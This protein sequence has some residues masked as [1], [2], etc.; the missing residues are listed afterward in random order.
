MSEEDRTILASWMVRRRALL[1]QR[2]QEEVEAELETDIS[3]L[4]KSTP[5]IR[6]LVH[7]AATINLKDTPLETAVLTIWDPAEEQ[8]SI[9]NE[10][11]VI[12]V[13]GVGVHSSIY[14]GFLQLSS[15]GKSPMRR[16]EPAA[17]S[18]IRK[19][20]GFE[21]RKTLN[22]F[23]AHV[24]AHRNDNPTEQSS[25]VKRRRTF[26]TVGVTV[27]PLMPSVGGMPG[28]ELYLTDQ[29]WLL[30]RVHFEKSPYEL[31]KLQARDRVIALNDL[32]MLEFDVMTNCA[33]ARYTCLSSVSKVPPE[34]LARLEQWRKESPSELERVSAYLEARVP[35]FESSRAATIIG[36]I[37]GLNPSSDASMLSI[38]VDSGGESSH[39]LSL[40]TSS[41]STIRDVVEKSSTFLLA[42]EE[43]RLEGM[44][45]L[46][47]LFR[48]HGV[49]FRFDVSKRELRNKFSWVVQKVEKADLQS[50]A[51]LHSLWP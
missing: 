7:T 25:N 9:L 40:P 37:V 38:E 19:T 43:S 8:L 27:S 16:S 42:S 50:M 28:Y 10:G 48:A 11:E 18:L 14:D 21:P 17:F 23:R 1:Q 15:R 29:S 36:A 47:F 44:T 4:R 5:F 46:D 49:Q 45:H 2:V 12:E 26:D 13:Q 3:L 35:L 34:C 32:Q 51:R 31:T 22:M 33:V 6:V 20:S 24:F 30:L 39:E 41:L